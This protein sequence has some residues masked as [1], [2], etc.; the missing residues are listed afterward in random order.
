MRSGK[1]NHF[2]GKRQATGAEVWTKADTEHE[3]MENLFE[4]G[5]GLYK[6]A[7]EYE[8]WSLGV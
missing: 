1:D 4:D 5:D 8:G 6:D 7:E 3:I 2:K